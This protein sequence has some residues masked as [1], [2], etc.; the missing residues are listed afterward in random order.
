[1]ITLGWRS[2]ST[3]MNCDYLVIAFVKTLD[4]T[5]FTLRWHCSGC[6]NIMV[7]ITALKYGFDDTGLGLWCH[8]HETMILLLHCQET[9]IALNRLWLLLV[10]LWYILTF[11][12]FVEEVF[13][14]T[15]MNLFSR[16]SNWKSLKEMHLLNEICCVHFNSTQDRK[17]LTLW[18]LMNLRVYIPVGGIVIELKIKFLGIFCAF[19]DGV[20]WSTLSWSFRTKATVQVEVK[21]L[22]DAGPCAA[23]F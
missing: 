3:V 1:M 21:L 15:L 23:S 7:D 8:Y 10:T 2:D 22:L 5:T 14:W 19:N 18:S 9:G 13:D 4:V 6:S 12:D 20:F 11:W 17:I 16:H